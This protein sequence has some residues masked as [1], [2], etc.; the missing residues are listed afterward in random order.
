MT[1]ARGLAIRRTSFRG[2]LACP[3]AIRWP[4]LMKLRLNLT[5]I[6]HSTTECQVKISLMCLLW[7]TKSRVLQRYTRAFMI[8]CIIQRCGRA[9][10]MHQLVQQGQQLELVVIAH[11]IPA[12]I[13][14]LLVTWAT[15]RHHI[16]SRHH[17]IWVNSILFIQ[18]ELQDQYSTLMDWSLRQLEP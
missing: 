5:S 17:T 11:R 13:A 7:Q 18:W 12:A 16:C 6:I 8:R 10:D 1:T 4:M 3:R 14:E 9:L 2:Y 15:S